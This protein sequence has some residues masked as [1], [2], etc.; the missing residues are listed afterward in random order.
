M[1]KIKKATACL[2]ACIATLSVCSCG[3]LGAKELAKPEKTQTLSY[4]E[5][6]DEGYLAFKD[7]TDEFSAKL[8]DAVYKRAEKDE[9]LAIAPLSVYTSPCLSP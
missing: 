2:C 8:S 5:R 3:Y 9:N 4:T 1:K 7:K 6:K